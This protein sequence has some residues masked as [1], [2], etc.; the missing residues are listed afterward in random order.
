MMTYADVAL[1]VLFGLPWLGVHLG[2]GRWGGKWHLSPVGTNGVRDDVLVVVPARNEALNIGACIKALRK[3]EGIDLAV[4]IVDD[5]SSDDTVVQALLAI[6]EDP[7]ISIMSAGPCPED[8]A[9]KSWACQQGSLE[10][11]ADWLLFVDADVR[12]HPL[13]AASMVSTARL[14]NL[15]I[16]SLFGTWELIGFWEKLLIPAIG[17]FIRGAIQIDSVNEGGRAFANGQCLLMR[18]ATYE[19]IGGHGAIRSSVLDDVDI[20]KA[21]FHQGGKG[22]LRIAPWA[23]SVRLYR[24]FNE[25]AQGYRKNL[26]AGMDRRPGVALAA[27]VVIFLLSAGPFLWLFAS[28]LLGDG[29]SVLVAAALCASVV[30]YRIRLERRDGRSGNWWLGFL[31]PLAGVFLSGLIL[32]SMLSGRTTWKD[33]SFRAGNA[34]H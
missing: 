18:T 32:W 12:V 7:A 30:T 34:E 29:Y 25:I 24:G 11:R 8:W 20:A 10:N 33:R 19:R 26:Y 16:L 3:S 5:N 14:E 13:T 2:M 23:F 22:G 9:G 31:H 6:E 17:W 28:T 4:H 27:T 15:D 1:G 21:V